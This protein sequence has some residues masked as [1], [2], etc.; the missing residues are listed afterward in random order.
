MPIG[1]C[2]AMIFFEISCVIPVARTQAGEL[3]FQREQPTVMI[4]SNC[5]SA[6]CF[7]EEGNIHHEELSRQEQLLLPPSP[8][9][10][11]RAGAGFAR[12]LVSYPASS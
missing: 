10:P 11:E 2:E 9:D 12:A 7:E 3:S 4:R 5:D 8:S 1:I 6:L